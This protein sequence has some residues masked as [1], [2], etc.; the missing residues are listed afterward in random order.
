MQHKQPRMRLRDRASCTTPRDTPQKWT[1]RAL[2]IAPSSQRLVAP[3][4]IENVVLIAIPLGENRVAGT[5]WSPPP[6]SSYRPAASHTYHVGYVIR[7]STLVH[8]LWVWLRL[9]TFRVRAPILLSSTLFGPL[10][11]LPAAATFCP[12]GPSS[13]PWAME[14]LP[15]L[16]TIPSLVPSDD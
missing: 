14:S 9:S 16:A 8:R 5:R 1:S 6:D 7:V 3:E 10:C 2:S 12:V 4:V 13:D 15:L 11:I